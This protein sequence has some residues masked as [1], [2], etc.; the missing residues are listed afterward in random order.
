M[1][2]ATILVV[3]DEQLIRWPLA[4]RLRSEPRDWRWTRTPRVV[5][6]T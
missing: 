5:R 6:P 2:H 1:S 4:E 3:D